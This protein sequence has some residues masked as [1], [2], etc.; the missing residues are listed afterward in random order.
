MY[1]FAGGLENTIL[2]L[3]LSVQGYSCRPVRG[4]EGLI[5]Q[6]GEALDFGL[7]P[8]N[9]DA[10]RQIVEDG[11]RA[12]MSLVDTEPFADQLP[13]NLAKKEVLSQVLYGST[14]SRVCAMHNAP[15]VSSEG[16]L[17]LD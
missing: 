10:V 14:T 13:S 8:T 17:W 12:F 16:P 7:I 4:S 11:W 15:T 5:V 1:T 9:A 6:S 3:L 2:S